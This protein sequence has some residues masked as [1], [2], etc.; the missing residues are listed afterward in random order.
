MQTCELLAKKPTQNNRG[1]INGHEKTNKMFTI[2][3]FQ[4]MTSLNSSM[5][6]KNNDNYYL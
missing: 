3:M 4:L 5:V 1:M 2:H 6:N